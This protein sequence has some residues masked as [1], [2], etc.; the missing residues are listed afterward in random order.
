MT[1]MIFATGLRGEFG[2]D[3]RLPWGHVPGDLPYF[4][5]YTE[6]CTLVMGR[7]TWESLPSKLPGRQ[8]VVLSST[9][10]EGADLTIS[11]IEE[12]R[13]IENVCIIG[14]RAVIAQALL[15]NL[16][17]ELSISFISGGPF[18]CDVRL[19]I[20]SILSDAFCNKDLKVIC[21]DFTPM[22]R[23][24]EDR[25]ALAVIE[26]DLAMAELANEKQRSASLVETIRMLREDYCA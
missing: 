11:D 9:P 8:H 2:R 1:K 14:G 26:R 13:N 5:E 19:P 12:I 7:R 16:V 25:L 3:G 23:S 21:K 22:E 6:G 15:L 10:V 18:E 20:D 17:D 24:L 4:K